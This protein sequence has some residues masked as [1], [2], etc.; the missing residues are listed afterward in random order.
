M[1]FCHFYNLKKGQ[2]CKHKLL[3]WVED[4][5]NT[6]QKRVTTDCEGK[7]Y[8]IDSI[9]FNSDI[10]VKVKTDKKAAL[11]FAI[12]NTNNVEIISPK[13]YRNYVTDTL[14]NGLNRYDNKCFKE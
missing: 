8:F 13:A 14:K 5:D 1:H 2:F 3:Y 4:I 11:S 6:P 10:F 12:N 7:N 9:H